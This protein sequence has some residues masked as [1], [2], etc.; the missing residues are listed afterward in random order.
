M[1]P[2]PARCIQAH[3][4]LRA[5]EVLTSVPP[6]NS[7]ADWRWILNVHTATYHNI[8]KSWQ[9][10]MLFWICVNYKGDL[11]GLIYRGVNTLLSQQQL[12]MSQIILSHQHQITDIYSFKITL[13]N[14]VVL[15][16]F[17]HWW[18]ALWIHCLAH[19]EQSSA[20]SWRFTDNNFA[21]NNP[22]NKV[23]VSC[24]SVT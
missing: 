6:T 12:L 3:H 23:A 19:N 5:E 17:S 8:L 4:L 9:C 24:F 11:A 20:C 7:P 14:D 15:L 1:Q 21:K 13:L 10:E 18:L 22:L 2:M 16:L